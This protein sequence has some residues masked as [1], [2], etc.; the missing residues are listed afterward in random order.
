MTHALYCI[1]FRFPN[2]TSFLGQDF[3]WFYN[4]SYCIATPIQIERKL[5]FRFRWKWGE[6]IQNVNSGINTKKGF[7]QETYTSRK[8]SHKTWKTIEIQIDFSTHPQTLGLGF[9]V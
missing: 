3:V 6:R 1:E 4:F 2:F 8:A 7:S 5:E 9:E